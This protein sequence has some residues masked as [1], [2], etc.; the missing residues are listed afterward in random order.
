MLPQS[1]LVSTYYDTPT[2]ALCRRERLALRVRRQRRRFVQTVKAEDP[3]LDALERRE[4]EEPIA[5]RG[6]C[7]GPFDPNGTIARL[8]A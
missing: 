8:N 2:L 7:C 3:N 5:R 6:P 1:D 4:G